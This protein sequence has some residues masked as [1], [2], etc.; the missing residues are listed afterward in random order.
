[1]RNAPEVVRQSLLARNFN[2]ASNK[3]HELPS[4]PSRI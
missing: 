3:I 1:M 2:L 4:Q